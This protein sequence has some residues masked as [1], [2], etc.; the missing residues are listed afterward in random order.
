[1]KRVNPLILVLSPVLVCHT[2]FLQAQVR[3]ADY[4]ARAREAVLAHLIE[5]G[6]H[7]DMEMLVPLSDPVQYPEH[8]PLH[9]RRATGEPA[10]RNLTVLVSDTT[11]APL[12]GTRVT[13]K[14]GNDQEVNRRSD[15]A[16]QAR[17]EGLPAGELQLEV[18]AA[19]FKRHNSVITVRLGQTRSVRIVLEYGSTSESVVT[20]EDSR[21]VPE[22]VV[23]MGANLA[24]T[25][26][27]AYIV[28]F[29]QGKARLVRL[30]PGR[31]GH[32]APLTEPEYG[33][34]L[35]ELEEF[36]Q[37]AADLREDRERFTEFISPALIA[38]VV[39]QFTRGQTLTPSMATD[40][41]A[42]WL[43]LGVLLEWADFEEI[44][45]E[46]ESKKP[47][48]PA[49]EGDVS[50]MVYYFSRYAKVHRDM[51]GQIGA[52]DEAHLKATFPYVRRLIG[53]GLAMKEVRG[54]GTESYAFLTAGTYYQV[55]LGRYLRL[56]FHREQ[57]RL[58]LAGFVIDD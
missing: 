12:A 33:L 34:V 6:L 41:I 55:P 53:E 19:G 54:A 48:Q 35:A 1:M 58:R 57:G 40:Y 20:G 10:E 21:R 18:E 24:Q 13:L 17:L 52:L 39:D 16:G 22:A 44:T 29:Q 42:G 32:R 7:P 8:F 4:V 2:W 14:S 26:F 56:Y 11:G 28:R 37:T 45:Q 27:R 47:A 43:D 3:N 49:S 15:G 38:G 23:L 51:L 9:K 5:T 36:Y 25:D 46:V 30:E 50:A 31:G